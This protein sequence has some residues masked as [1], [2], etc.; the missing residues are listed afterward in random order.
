MMREP[1]LPTLNEG[2]PQHMRRAQAIATIRKERRRKRENF[3]NTP[4]K[5]SLEYERKDEV[6]N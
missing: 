6:I 1:N 5:V 2:S 4:N 3:N